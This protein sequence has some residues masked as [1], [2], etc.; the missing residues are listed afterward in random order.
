MKKEIKPKKFKSFFPFKTG[1]K[2]LES[3]IHQ[4]SQK[5][6]LVYRR[7]SKIDGLLI[8]NDGKH[9]VT[10]CSSIEKL[11]IWNVT[12]KVI[13]HF[14]ELDYKVATAKFVPNGKYL[15]ISTENGKLKVYDLK[16]LEEVFT[17]DLEHKLHL[18]QTIENHYF[19]GIDFENNLLIGKIFN[20][21]I[22]KLKQLKGRVYSFDICCSKN[23]LGYTLESRLVV[24]MDLSSKK[25]IFKYHEQAD[26]LYC[27]KFHHTE[28]LVF[29]SSWNST[30]KVFSY[31]SEQFTL[32]HTFKTKGFITDFYLIDK[33]VIAKSSEK[34]IQKLEFSRLEPE[35]LKIE[36]MIDR[37]CVNSEKNWLLYL[38]PECHIRCEDLNS[39][40]ELF[41]ISWH[42]EK[43]TKILLWESKKYFV[44]ASDDK[45][46]RVWDYFNLK[47][48]A[49]HNLHLNK[50]CSLAIS[51]KGGLLVYC[52]IDQKITVFR[53]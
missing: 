49:V 1:A 9:L 38:T 36:C 51:K 2:H 8:S 28:P 42:Y 12:N 37:F 33:Q 40:T 23:L 50:S 10:W 15:L 20:K 27:I 18:L 45:S 46:V 52:G 16:R 35:N 39:N 30:I 14:R 17:V 44:T 21:K 3:T 29:I 26:F 48:V 34:K 4:L 7:I 31:A 53:H 43:I 25:I 22:E 11:V 19:Y 32:C 5:G 6:L 24:F 47:C 13:C 41:R